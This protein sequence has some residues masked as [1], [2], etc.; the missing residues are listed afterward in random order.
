MID[1]NASLFIGI[2]LL[3]IIFLIRKI[4]KYIDKKIKASLNQRNEQLQSFFNHTTDAIN[5]TDTNGNILYINK[6]F[7]NMFGWKR[8]E[9]LGKPLP[10]I[11][12]HL[13]EDEKQN[14]QALLTG[15]PISNWQAQFIRK[16]GFYIDVNV[17][18]SPLIN[19]DGVIEGFAGVT[20]D[21]SKL[22]LAEKKLKEE[23][24]KFRIIA[25]N[26]SDLIRLIDINGIIQYASPSHL[27]LLGYD[28]D[29]IIGNHFTKNIHPEDD[30]RVSQFFDDM[31][32][33]PQT[34]II[35][36][37]KKHRDG[38]YLC[39]EA[40]CAPSFDESGNLC[41][42][43]AVLRDISE[44]KEYEKKLKELAF[45]DPLTGAAN[46]RMLQ[47]KLLEAI[48]CSKKENTLFAVLILD[49]D[50]F[51]WVND[52]MGHDVGDKMLKEFAVR[53]KSVIRSTDI[54]CRHGGDEFTV[55]LSEVHSIDEITLIAK[56]I[57]GELQ[58]EWFIEG[59]RFVAT[60]SIGI[61][62]YPTDGEDRHSLL[63]HADHALYQAKES[64]R[65]SF[66][67]YVQT[68]STIQPENQ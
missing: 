7:E 65:N 57:L 32:H 56:R 23:E 44:R 39:M 13:N 12:E 38:Y 51:K 64:G 68:T 52:T 21:E 40:H 49:C 17:T 62:V 36:Y 55:I 10:I 22:K 67:Y 48:E 33:E 46:R 29:D 5:I 20:R 4:P 25:E 41:H 1:F 60:S 58:K 8:D 63:T 30:E 31:I 9:I 53:V 27:S 54:L 37:R 11:P 24:E 35:E 2:S 42:L 59:H 43:I 66:Q 47:R 15:K 18:V 14:R 6:A 45:Y 50:R 34:A 28:S 26:S 16:D 61:S 19:Q 3:F